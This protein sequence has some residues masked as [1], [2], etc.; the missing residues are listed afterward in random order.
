MNTAPIFVKVE[1]HR[2]VIDVL[3]A[4]HMKLAEAK[5]ALKKIQELKSQEDNE[6][7]QWQSEIAK[8]EEK[9]DF[10]HDAMSRE[11]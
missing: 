2:E 7:M 5:D 10:V 1:K 3:E 11:G 8:V 6:L 9:L 4:I